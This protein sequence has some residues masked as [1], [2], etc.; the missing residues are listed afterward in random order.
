MSDSNSSSESVSASPSP[1][2]LVIPAGVEIVGLGV[3]SILNGDI[4][5]NGILTNLK[6][7]GAIT[8]TGELRLVDNTASA[9]GTFTTDDGKT[10]TVL[11]GLV[12]SII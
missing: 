9:S 3:N 12:I 6:V 8:G 7:T 2:L 10:V 1:G 4:E 5:N 11:D